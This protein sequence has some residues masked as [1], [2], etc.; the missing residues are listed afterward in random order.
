MPSN[1]RGGQGSYDWEKNVDVRRNDSKS[2]LGMELTGS[3]AHSSN[4]PMLQFSNP[5]V[6]QII[7]NVRNEMMMNNTLVKQPLVTL[8]TSIFYVPS[9]SVESFGEFESESGQ[10]VLSI[11]NNNEVIQAKMREMA[12]NS[13]LWRDQREEDDEE[14][15]GDGFAGYSS[16]E[17]DQAVDQESAEAGN[18]IH[19]AATASKQ[20]DPVDVTNKNAATPISILQQQKSNTN[21]LDAS[22]ADDRKAAATLEVWQQQIVTTVPVISAEERKLLDAMDVYFGSGNISE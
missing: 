14:N 12:I 17:G 4:A 15:W 7:K 6:E 16:E 9:Q 19:N 2:K 11:G 21:T 13:K 20:I 3:Q 1:E 18:L 8:N 22:H 5:H 10:H